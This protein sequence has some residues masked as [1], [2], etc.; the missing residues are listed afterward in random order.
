[1]EGMVFLEM[2][3]IGVELMNDGDALIAIDQ[4]LPIR[5]FRE[6]SI[7]RWHKAK[8]TSAPPNNT[9]VPLW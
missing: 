3:W 4:R 1:M 2:V 5:C 6:G 8:V 9:N 7:N